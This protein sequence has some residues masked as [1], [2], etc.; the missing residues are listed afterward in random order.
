MSFSSPLSAPVLTVE[1]G[2]SYMTYGKKYFI[3]GMMEYWQALKMRCD[4][5]LSAVQP[6]CEWRRKRTFTAVSFVAGFCVFA[7]VVFHK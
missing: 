6:A 7:F 3:L 2:Y 5:C 1:G 4:V